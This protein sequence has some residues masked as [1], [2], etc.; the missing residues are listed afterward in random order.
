MAKRAKDLG[1]PTITVRYCPITP[2]QLAEKRREREIIASAIF[3][4]VL[5]FP[6]TATIYDNGSNTCSRKEV[7]ICHG[8]EVVYPNRTKPEDLPK[9]AIDAINSD[10]YKLG[11]R[12]VAQM[13]KDKI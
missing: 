11:E 7:H 10:V 3:S 9:W 8:D 4:H 6:V 5:G 2:E 1:T 13:M 12:R